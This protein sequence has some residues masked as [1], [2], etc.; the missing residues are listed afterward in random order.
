MISVNTWSDPA[1]DQLVNALIAAATDQQE[2]VQQEGLK[3]LIDFVD[4]GSASEIDHIARNFPWTRFLH[5]VA[6]AKLQ[7]TVLQSA[8]F[9]E[10]IC[11]LGSCAPI[12]VQQNGVP[13]LNSMLEHPN[14]AIFES[15]AR[16]VALLSRNDLV[17][18]NLDSCIFSL[19]RILR[20]A[21]DS[22][23]RPFC[24]EALHNICVY[25]SSDHQFKERVS[26]MLQSANLDSYTLAE[27]SDFE[28]F[29][30]S[31][32]RNG[33]FFGVLATSLSVVL[34]L[35]LRYWSKANFAG[36][37]TKTVAKALPVSLSA[38]LGLYTVTK[39]SDILTDSGFSRAGTWVVGTVV[40]CSIAPY[41]FVPAVIGRIVGAAVTTNESCVE[42]RWEHLN[43]K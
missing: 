16:A 21:Q 14:S 28:R 15:A 11:M 4:Q 8:A 2:T 39:F 35:P 12:V 6:E 17:V 29:P 10:S 23:V 13:C 41:V 38:A 34:Y 40:F 26:K 27:I 25:P 30:T 42:D 37:L 19:S 7:D 24:L 18:E 31:T 32:G 22:S 33:F 20:D 43:K 36:N 9:F 5:L 3:I 1:K